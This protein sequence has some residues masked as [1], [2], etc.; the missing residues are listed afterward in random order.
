M[1]NTKIKANDLMAESKVNANGNINGQSSALDLYK[2]TATEGLG[3]EENIESTGDVYQDEL[4]K[5]AKEKNYKN[6]Y[7]SAM[8]LYNYEQNS[9]K[10]LNNSLASAGLNTQGYGSSQ[11]AGINNQAIN[12]YNQNLNSLNEAN[13]T[14]DQEALQRKEDADTEADEQLITFMSNATSLNQVNQ[15]L[16]NY[17]YVDDDGNVDTSKMNAY[18]KSI[19]DEKTGE[20][21]SANTSTKTVS[22][23]ISTFSSTKMTDSDKTYSDKY[24]KQ[25]NR[26]SKALEKEGIDN[27]ANGT[28]F[29]VSNGNDDNAVYFVYKD[30]KFSLSS[31]E[32]YDSSDNKILSYMEGS[33]SQ[34]YKEYSRMGNVYVKA[35]LGS[36]A[37][38]DSMKDGKE[39]EITYQGRK[40]AVIYANGSW[41]WKALE[42]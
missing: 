32:K 14:A 18:V 3:G 19:Y 8:Q 25:L 42:Y 10:Y 29:C 7:N 39:H 2:T 17:G 36:D 35:A 5:A 24:S 16:K 37:D 40:C 12:L 28:V 34:Y 30:G 13:A 33:T 6:F 27:I 31:K 9:K 23:A 38:E 20:I 11:M 22:S 21:N 15:Y 26:I 41:Y 1:A 4:S